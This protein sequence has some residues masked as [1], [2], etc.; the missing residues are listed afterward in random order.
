MKN[1]S[2]NADFL[3]EWFDK[4]GMRLTQLMK[5]LDVNNV[6]LKRWMRDKTNPFPVEKMI[7]FCNLYG[8]DISEFF[9]CDGERAEIS[10]DSAGAMVVKCDAPDV[11]SQSKYLQSEILH[12]KEIQRIQQESHDREETL[13]QVYQQREDR[14]REDYEK[15]IEEYKS[16]LRDSMDTTRLALSHRDTLPDGYGDISYGVA[17][18]KDPPYPTVNPKKR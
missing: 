6:S 9:L 8:V 2:Y 12:L 16:M 7:L 10:H 11:V 5:D 18:L 1:Y 4:S 15:R 14:L 3:E 17:D 13:R